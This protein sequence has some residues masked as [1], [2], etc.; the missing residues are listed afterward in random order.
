MERIV[1]PLEWAPTT[2]GARVM[3]AAYCLRRELGECLK[4]RPRL[5][6]DL[7]LET[8]GH[9]YRLEFDCKR[10]EMSLIDTSK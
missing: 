6:G 2:S 4:E 8:G 7:Y 3:Q 5:R 10:C 1:E 9:R